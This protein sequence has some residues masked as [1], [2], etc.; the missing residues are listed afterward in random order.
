MGPYYSLITA[1]ARQR[2]K[3]GAGNLCQPP[4]HPVPAPRL[5]PT[6]P[7]PLKSNF[8]AELANFFPPSFSQPSCL[9]VG[10]ESNC[11]PKKDANSR[12]AVRDVA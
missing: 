12:E 4:S 2:A 1:A 9:V 5:G 7:A 10:G 8:L 6:R 11:L 3:H